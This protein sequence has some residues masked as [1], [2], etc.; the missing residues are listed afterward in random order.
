MKTKT[1]VKRKFTTNRKSVSYK[2][3]QEKVL[4]WFSKGR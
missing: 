1:Y 4:N 2:V 3:V